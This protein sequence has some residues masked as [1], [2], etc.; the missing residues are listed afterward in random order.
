MLSTTLHQRTTQQ[1]R[2]LPAAHLTKTMQLLEKTC[3]DLET[4]VSQELAE[5]PALELVDELRCPDCKAVIPSFPCQHCVSRM[6][7]DD[8]IVSVSPRPT[9]SER[10]G[11]D[12]A[13]YTDRLRQPETLAE[14]ILR[15]VAPAL[16]EEEQRVAS[17]I[18][19]QLDKHGFFLEHPAETA[20]YLR[21]R[22]A[23]VQRVLKLIHQSDPVGL[24]TSGVQECLLAQIESL[25]AEGTCHPLAQT[26]LVDYLEDLGRRDYK[27]IARKCLVSE[28]EVRDAAE[29]IHDNLAPYPAQAWSTQGQVQGRYQYPDVQI[30]RNTS[31]PDGPLMVEVFM[32]VRGWLRVDPQVRAL[33]KQVKDTE[34]KADWEQCV[35][36]ASLFVKCMQQRNN[37][38]RRVVREV[39]KRQPD[40]ILGGDADLVP[41]TRAELAKVLNL[42]ESTIS[43]AVAHKTIGLPNGRIILMAKFFDR[44]LAVRETVRMII[45]EETK[46]LTDDQV[47]AAL[48]D[49]GYKVARRT[50]AKYRSMLRILPAN[51]RARQL[52]RRSNGSSPV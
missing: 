47:A 10:P 45:D 15:Q 42:H 6:N 9:A 33:V 16:S 38:M 50:V 43:R 2:Q 36:R 4:E 1:Q 46:P 13:P 28:Q 21:T 18:V 26:L 35:E 49:Y 3:S 20:V 27:L 12:D 24:A 29:F 8:P 5:N 22:L 40:F 11:D 39:V 25:E 51:L 14:H 37:G 44:S 52:P 7:G 41:M 30:N 34:K 23:T 17:Y 32:A 19:V 48:R 31:E